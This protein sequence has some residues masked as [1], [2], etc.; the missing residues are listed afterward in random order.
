M[1]LVN[2]INIK[3]QICE[4]LKQIQAIANFERIIKESDSTIFRRFLS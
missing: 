1:Y 2:S 3:N 4:L